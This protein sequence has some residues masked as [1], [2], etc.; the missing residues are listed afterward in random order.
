M[1]D[2]IQFR[3]DT[4]ERW[5]ASN[6]IL[7]EGELGLILDGSNQWK[8]GDGIRH[9]NDLPLGLS[10]Y[11]G[12]IFDK[13]GYDFEGVISQ[14][15]IT[16]ILRNIVTNRSQILLSQLDT[17]TIS[18]QGVYA[19]IKQS[20][21]NNAVGHLL[22]GTTPNSDAVNQWIFGGFSIENGEISENNGKGFSIL[23]RNY[24]NGLWTPWQYFQQKFIKNGE[25]GVDTGEEWTY[26][27]KA[28][29]ALIKNVSAE[30]GGNIEEIEKTVE[31]VNAAITELEKKIDDISKSDASDKLSRVSD[32]VASGVITFE[33]GVKFGT[34]ADKKSIDENGNAN[35][36]TVNSES[37]INSGNFRNNGNIRNEYGKITTQTLEV[38]TDAKTKNLT[39]TGKAT[40]FELEVLKAS[41]VGG[42]SVYSAGAGKI[43]LVEPVYDTE[44]TTNVTGWKCYQLAKDADGVSLQQ[45]FKEG[46]NLVSFSFNTGAGYYTGAANR[47]WWRR[48]TRAGFAYEL[49]NGQRYISFT[50]SKA[51][52]A[53]GS[54]EPK[55]GDKVCVLG[56][57]S[58]I[59]RQKAIIISAYGGLD[60]G[61]IAPYIAQYTGINDFDLA[62]HRKSHW[63]YDA[64]GNPDNKFIGNFSIQ[65]SGGTDT[66]LVRD[67]GEWQA[68]MYYYYDRVSYKGSLYLMT[69]KASDTTT[70]VP[71]VSADWTLQV[72]KGA[73]GETGMSISLKGNAIAHYT[74]DT[75]EDFSED[76]LY[77]LDKTAD[78]L[79]AVVASVVQGN[80]ANYVTPKEGDSYITSSDGHLWTF[81][82]LWVDC[83][84]IKGE[85]GDRGDKG[86]TGSKGADGKDGANGADGVK[87]A[88]GADA[89]I[90]QLV[91][92]AEN[93]TLL[94]SGSVVG[95]LNYSI[96]MKKGDTLTLVELSKEAYWQWKTE[97]S[98]E[99]NAVKT[100]GN[101]PISYDFSNDAS[102]NIIVMLIINGIT[103]DTRIIRI[104]ANN[105]AFI[106]YCQATNTISATVQKQTN[107]IS[108]LTQSSLQIKAETAS[109]SSR[110]GKAEAKIETSVQ[111]DGN[112]KVITE[113]KLSSDQI[114]LSGSVTANNEF[115]IDRWGNVMTGTQYGVSTTKYIVEDKSNLI[116]TSNTQIT[117]PNDPEYIGRK[118]IIL[119]QPKFNSEGVVID[120]FPSVTIKTAEVFTR[121]VYGTSIADGAETPDTVIEQIDQDGSPFA[122][123][124]YFG[125]NVAYVNNGVMQMPKKLIIQGGYVEL[126]GVE[127]L[128][129]RT[130][131]SE[132]PKFNNEFYRVHMT[133][134]DGEGVS[135][136]EEP[137]SWIKAIDDTDADNGSIDIFPST[138]ALQ[139]TA[140]ESCEKITLWTV[141][142]VDAKNFAYE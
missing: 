48:C 41:A 51:N 98:T 73:Q 71:G 134:T 56:N 104:T 120:G 75:D 138:T 43:D 76:G 50:V 53:E 65:G 68:G 36:K 123:V 117:L 100:E 84:V 94:A 40:F 88:D 140:W 110:M 16:N 136:A 115:R 14:G 79:G 67:L 131:R 72:A 11:D 58:N 37:I 33:K 18:E 20:G 54:G 1:A 97:N 39:V 121:G 77:L 93:V 47:W 111:T 46:D 108:T 91:P 69:N 106:G 27:H 23:V 4:A 32:D 2:L 78:G 87:G 109:L 82:N 105:D 101:V 38:L 21:D 34:T 132:T 55:V 89:V 128:T 90:Y 31:A 112:G 141:I 24:K 122:G 29:D 118:V 125:G 142:N 15:G 59:D 127:Y 137:Y 92:N 61:L 57:R 133:R 42:L 3:R 17:L 10:N 30:T 95:A 83:G 126:L 9:W 85:K 62:S 60:A 119:S 45:M 66:P 113:I 25:L 52:C 49:K 64:L 5:Q 63:G 96:Y 114:D 81:G 13:L 12:N 7:A 26:G 44:D 28:I 74:I 139:E 130:F 86:E 102:G 22:L 70:G 116:F 35:L 19:L 8:I 103:Q 6:P 135:T 99:W 129:A 80:F 107:D 124:R